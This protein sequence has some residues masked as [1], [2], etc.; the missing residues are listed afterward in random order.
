MRPVQAKEERPS[1]AKSGKNAT[2]RRVRHA[3]RPTAEVL[4]HA[5]QFPQDKLGQSFEVDITTIMA[6]AMPDPA[7]SGPHSTRISQRKTV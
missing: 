2:P 5:E 3:G 4:A 7:L 6:V 1:Y